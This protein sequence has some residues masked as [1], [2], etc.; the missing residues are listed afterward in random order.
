MSTASGVQ[1]LWQSS[2]GNRHPLW[3][4]P[5]YVRPAAPLSDLR[6]LRY[7]HQPWQ[8]HSG[9]TVHADLRPIAHFGSTDFSAGM[10]PRGWGVA[11]PW[12]KFSERTRYARLGS[13][14]S[15]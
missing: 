10:C 8:R 6:R 4:D 7:G 12:L 11:D 1:G 5:D 2:D 15:R 14:P 13:S 3:R 9:R